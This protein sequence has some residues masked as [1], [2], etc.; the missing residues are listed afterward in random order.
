MIRTALLSLLLVAGI[1]RAQDFDS[2]EIKSVRV[3]DGIHMLTGRGGNIGLSSGPDGVFLIDDQ[4]A[5]LTGKITA[6]VRAISPEPI[7]FVLNT[8]WHG[9][10]TGGNENLGAAGALIV[11]HENVRRRMSVEQFQKLRG[12]TLP[13][14]PA[15]ALPVV[16]FSDAV[17]FHWN[18]QEIH[19]QHLTA[20]HTDGDTVVHFRRANVVHA[21][22]TFFNG[23]YPFIDLDSGG[24]LE[25][26]IAAVDRILPLTDEKTRIIP[27]HGPLGDRAQLETYRTML[28]RVGERIGTAVEKGRTLDEVLAERPTADFDAEWGGGFLDPE[29]F[30]RILYADLSGTA[31]PGTR[32]P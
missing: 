14:S 25:G 19:C 7:R 1:A 24:S 11:A 4:F 10:H 28:A 20:A 17:T 8:H 9:D 29:T 26:T 15:G 12:R 6:A 18:G 2:V 13:A 23:V 22:D 30:V 32:E 16:T 27:G 21:G 5:P 31:G 3:A